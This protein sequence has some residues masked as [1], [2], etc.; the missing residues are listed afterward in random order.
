MAAHQHFPADN[1]KD[2]DKVAVRFSTDEGRAWSE[3]QVIQLAGL[4]EGMRF[5]FDPTLV[6]LPEG[7][8]R[9]Y[10][11]SLKGRRFEAYRPAIYSAISSNGIDFTFEPGTR[12]SV[13]GRPVID[14]AV[15]L[16]EGVF[17]LFAPD[18]GA[19][20]APGMRPPDMGERPS[21]GK[22]YHATSTDGLNFKRHEDV[23]L[24]G[25]V[26]WLGNALSDGGSLRFFGTGGPNGAWSA[27]SNNGHRWKVDEAFPAVPGADPGAVKLNDGGWL[28]A[29]TGPARRGRPRIAS[30]ENFV[31]LPPPLGL[32]DTLDAN[33]DGTIDSWELENA[34]KLLRKL[35]RNGDGQLTREELGPPPHDRDRPPRDQP[36]PQPR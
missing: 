1:D 34:A 2:F 18:N 33:Q 31:H 25:A 30:D 29:V 17:H 21:E 23:R 14:C 6:A 10:F 32:M 27:T 24:D 5:P 22:G 26:R 8:V 35:D 15:T 7:G 11:T 16:H 20:N 13:E 9:L 19:E 36:S 12:F 3:P 4:P 28:L